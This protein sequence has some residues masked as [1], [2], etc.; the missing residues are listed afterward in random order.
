VS[1]IRLVVCVVVRSHLAHEPP[2]DILV[3]DNIAD[4]DRWKAKKRDHR[5]FFE[6]ARN[7]LLGMCADGVSPFKVSKTAYSML[8]CVF[9]LYN[10]PS[11]LRKKYENLLIW[12]IMEGKLRADLVFVVMVEDMSEL[13]RGVGVWDSFEEETFCLRAM[14]V[15][16]L[17]DYPGFT[18]TSKQSAH[19]AFAGCVECDIEGAHVNALGTRIYAR[20]LQADP[21]ADF[22]LKDKAWIEG[23]ANTMEV[24][25]FNL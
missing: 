16:M 22:V 7:L 19:G 6:D 17:H 15:N 11:D 25:C 12:G 1:L 23:A 21:N 8:C 4:G 20:R 18:Q 13:W 24:W 3:S 10:L 5:R 2:F 14:L 9:Q